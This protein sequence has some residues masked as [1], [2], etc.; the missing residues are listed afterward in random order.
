[1]IEL[2][3]TKKVVQAQAKIMQEFVTLQNNEK[4]KL[5]NCYECIAKMWGFKNW[6]TFSKFLEGEKNGN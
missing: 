4:M 1:M 5:S 3:P 2:Y 6:N